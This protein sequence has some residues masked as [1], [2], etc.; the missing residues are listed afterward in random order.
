[1][2]LSICR[3]IICSED[4]RN[5]FVWKAGLSDVYMS[6][7]SVPF[8]DLHVGFTVLH[9]LCDS[10]LVLPENLRSRNVDSPP[11]RHGVAT[12]T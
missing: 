10:G 4:A 1:M 3:V 12:T 11:K 5:I 8:R 7:I 2:R 6:R 9:S